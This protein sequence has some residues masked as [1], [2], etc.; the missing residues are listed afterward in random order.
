MEPESV[1]FVLPRLNL[2]A[3]IVETAE[4]MDRKAFIPEF[5]VE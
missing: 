3:Y 5:P 2:G 4:P 1:I